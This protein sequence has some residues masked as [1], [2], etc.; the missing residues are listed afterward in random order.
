MKNIMGKKLSKE[1]IDVMIKK[2]PCSQ[3]FDIC[4]KCDGVEDYMNMSSLVDDSSCTD[5]ICYECDPT[6]PDFK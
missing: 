1:E 2:N 3:V 4:C 6:K 5:L